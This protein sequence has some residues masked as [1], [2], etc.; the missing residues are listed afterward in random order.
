MKKINFFLSNLFNKNNNINQ[1]EILASKE[2]SWITEYIKQ[3]IEQ[4]IDK[5]KDRELAI[6]PYGEVAQKVEEILKIM[7]GI[8]IRY[9]VDDNLKND[10]LVSLEQFVKLKRNDTLV[11]FA[12]QN[13]RYFRELL[14]KLFLAGISAK[15]MFII[16]RNLILGIDAVEKVISYE[17]QVRLLDIGCGQGLQGRMFQDYGKDVV[18]LTMSKNNGYAGE[19]I[20]KV[21]YVDFLK[22][23][24]D[25]KFDIVWASHM[26]EHVPN[27]QEF[28]DKMKEHVKK[29]GIIA[30][31]VPAREK[32]IL[33]THVHS[34]SAGRILRYLL[35]AGID[36]R[37]AEILEY[38]YNLSVIIPDIQFI[39][40]NYDVEGMQNQSADFQ[41]VDHIFKYLPVNIQMNKEWNNIYSF[42]GDIEKLNWRS[43]ESRFK[44]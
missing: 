21:E 10:S 7:Y 11:I 35:C 34:F 28:V 16:S 12:T 41:E 43:I 22:Y 15:S 2:E 14:G 36:C 40:E 3:R 6:Y 5:L 20:S 18:G 24:S 19:C 38:G 4:N 30:I 25:K 13:Q 26:L 17:K 32:N 31:T 29:G 1:A 9:H 39:S 27:V 44:I 23:K 8:N 37:N 42:N 33:L